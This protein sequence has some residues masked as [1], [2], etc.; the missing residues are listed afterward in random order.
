MSKHTILCVDDEID[1]VD[2]LERLFR[3]KYSVL[4][5]T[6]GKEALEVLAKNPGPLALIITDQRM[7]EM[8]GVE[9]LEKTVS[10]HPDTVR[11]LLTGYT[12]LESVITAVNKGQIFRY[13]TKPWDP[14]DLSNTVD[15]AV[16]RFA[17]GQELKVKNQELAKALD[18]LKSLD[19]AKSNFM[20]LINHELKTP[21]TSILS[22]SSLLSESNLADDDRL[23]V[24]RITKSAERLK[25]LVED[26]LLIVRAETNQLKIDQQQVAF[27]QFDEGLSKDLT[28]MLAK[29]HQKLISKLEPL[30]VKADVRL[31]KQVMSRLIHNAAKFGNESS[32]IHIESLRNGNNLRFLVHNRGPQLPTS[33]IDKIT[34]PFYIDEDV[35]HHSSG[36]GLGLTICQSILK[37]HNSNL[38]F[39][40]TDQGVMV[41]FELPLA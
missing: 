5:A 29:K 18:E 12:D 23:M 28:D 40:N 38:Q 26:V 3:K 37:S 34:K 9:F 19:V 16:E 4:K 8:T 13:L 22:F 20:I 10:S 24:N 1:N 14:T 15:H 41:F 32:E 30:N 21:L 33:V 27:T 39:K 2:A 36:T 7:P 35:M 31:I 6:S 17:V 11:I 25:N